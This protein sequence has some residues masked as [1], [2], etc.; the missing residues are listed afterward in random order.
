MRIDAARADGDLVLPRPRR[1]GARGP[2]GSVHVCRR[3]GCVWPPRATAPVRGA[4][5]QEGVGREGDRG[6]SLVVRGKEA[7]GRLT[8]ARCPTVDDQELGARHDG[9]GARPRR[10]A[11]PAGDRASTRD[12]G[13]GAPRQVRGVP[14]QGR[15]VSHVV[16]LRKRPAPRLARGGQ[17]SPRSPPWSCRRTR[18]HPR[19]GTERRRVVPPGGPA[20]P[21]GSSGN[22]DCQSNR[23]NGRPG[24]GSSG[25]RRFRAPCARTVPTEDAPERGRS[26][27]GASS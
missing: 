8:R 26:P 15:R 12:E 5:E 23:G 24:S 2:S 7:R 21:I 11:S 25:D 18:R 6:R 17:G 1:G 9:A 22:A 14:G 10:D 19:D 16:R 13:V 4:A 27:C 20:V 3:V